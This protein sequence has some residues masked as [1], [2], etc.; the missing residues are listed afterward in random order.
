MGNKIRQH[1]LIGRGLLV[2]GFLFF[3]P[4]LGGAQPEN[5]SS[6][7]ALFAQ[8]N[9]HYEKG[10]YQ[11]AV[12]LYQHLVEC[13][14]ESGHL[15]YNLGNSYFKLGEKGQ[16]V[17]YYE[18]ARRLIPHDADL[19]A[20]LAYALSGVEEGGNT[21]W[22]AVKTAVTHLAPLGTWITA[23]SICYALFFCCLILKMLFPALTT[24]PTGQPKTWWRR[25]VVITGALLLL[26]V[27]LGALT[28][29]GQN[30]PQGVVLTAGDALFE[31]VVGASTHYHLSP[32]IRVRILE[33]KGEWILV[34]R[35]DGK[36]GWVKKQLVGEL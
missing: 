36:R 3:L 13:G 8:A 2:L 6:P 31:P 22:L 23:A 26:T 1:N 28:F 11:A 14:Y 32:G 24:N 16:A 21:W 17:L 9:T 30:T 25:S 29:L 18:K 4:L 7:E 33:E 15:F 12:A 5:P 35:P 19:K 10:E 20:N 34:R 27:S